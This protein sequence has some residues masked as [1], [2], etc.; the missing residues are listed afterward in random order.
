MAND[1]NQTSSGKIS[2][3]FLVV[4]VTKEIPKLSA[5]DIPQVLCNGPGTCVPLCVIAFLF[6]V[7]VFSLSP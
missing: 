6:K 1:S 2:I 7:Y 5:T 3:L 4:S